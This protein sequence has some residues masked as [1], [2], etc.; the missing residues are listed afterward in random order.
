MHGNL[1][2]ESL[3]GKGLYFGEAYAPNAGA[4]VDAA[5]R[6]PAPEGAYLIKEA[7]SI[8]PAGVPQVGLPLTA[9]VTIALLSR[10][11][12]PCKG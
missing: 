1:L 5:A 4:L 9:P 7:N 11:L 3:T 10:S 12:H 8:A 6:A 2:Q